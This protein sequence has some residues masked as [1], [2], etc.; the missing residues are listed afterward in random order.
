MKKTLAILLAAIMLLSVSAAV[1]EGYNFPATLKGVE[2][3]PEMPEVPALKTKNDGVTQTVTADGEFESLSA[4]VNWQW[5]PITFE[6]GVA[7]FSMDDFKKNQQGT[8]TYAGMWGY[9]GSDG[10][11]SWQIATAESGTYKG[12]WEKW[13]EGV[14]YREYVVDNGDGTE[15]LYGC[16]YGRYSGTYEMGFA[17]DGKTADGISVKYDRF[18]APVVISQEFTGLNLLGNEVDPVKT[19]VTWIPLEN[20]TGIWV[21]RYYI[22]N[23]TEEFEE[24]DI[25][26]ISADFS[27]NGALMAKSAGTVVTAAEAPAEEEAEE[28]VEE[29]AE[30]VVEEAAEEVVE[31]VTE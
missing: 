29:A 26:S 22:T 19:T 4:V 25:A 24:G 15:T 16:L 3:V 10:D 5:L 30:E 1:A 21:G 12:Y 8:G 27:S 31:E 6:D 28:V 23:I 14:Y 13:G 17:Y 9:P 18:G 2:G 7:T 11:N 20:Y